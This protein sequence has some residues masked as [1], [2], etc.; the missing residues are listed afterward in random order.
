MRSVPSTP[1][2]S[3]TLLDAEPGRFSFWALHNITIAVWHDQPTRDAVLRLQQAAEARAKLHPEGVSDVHVVVGPIALPDDHTRQALIRISKLAVPYL[4]A[5]GVIV[6]GSGFW[7]STMRSLITGIR[8]LL[9]GTFEFGLFGTTEEL[10]RWL[11]GVH[12]KRTGLQLDAAVLK[13]ALEFVRQ[14]ASPSIAGL[15]AE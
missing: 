7:A 5:V 4:A 6:G 1:T 14:N 10:V 3:P 15:P 13:R 9:P 11:P 2:E 8:V 12:A